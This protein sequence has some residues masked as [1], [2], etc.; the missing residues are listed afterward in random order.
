VER[1]HTEGVLSR[2]ALARALNERGVPTST[3]SG[4]W[5]HTTVARVLARAAT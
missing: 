5:T 3:G 4:A 1:L 2:S